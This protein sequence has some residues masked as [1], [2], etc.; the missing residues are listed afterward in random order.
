MHALKKLLYD[1]GRDVNASIT[2][3]N[4]DWHST[5]AVYRFFS[6]E[7]VT[8]ENLL[9]PHIES[10]YARIQKERDYC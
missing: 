2:G 5:N 10:T 1:L 6:R 3:A 8:A 4:D 9:F 7:D